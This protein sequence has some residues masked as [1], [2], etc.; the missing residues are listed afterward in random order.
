[1]PNVKEPQT[2]AEQLQEEIAV[3]FRQL[4][5]RERMQVAVALNLNDTVTL[6]RYANEEVKKIPLG[7]MMRDTM[8]KVLAER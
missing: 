4:T 1:M 8:Q 6:Y 3:L 7:T 2:E 5:G